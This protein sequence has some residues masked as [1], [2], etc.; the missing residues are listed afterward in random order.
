MWY[1]R[2]R[3]FLI[4]LGFKESYSD[5]SLFILFREDNVFFAYVDDIVMTGSDQDLVPEVMDAM[6]KEFALKELGDLGY[7][8]GI[9]VKRTKGDYIFLNSST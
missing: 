3:E 9:H 1:K 6:G 8:L 4:K 7:F 2:P 5:P